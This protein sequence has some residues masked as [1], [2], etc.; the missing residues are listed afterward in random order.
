VEIGRGAERIVAVGRGVAKEAPRAAGLLGWHAGMQLPYAGWSTAVAPGCVVRSSGETLPLHRERLDAGWV[1]GAELARGVSTVT[2]TFAEAPRTVVIVLDDP[3]A[4]GG[5]VGGRQLLLGLDGA[6]RPRDARGRDRPPVLLTME[7]RS[8]L[9]YDVIPQRG[10]PVVVT[11]AS[12]EGWS[13]V[14]VLGSAELTAA[15]AIAL[16]S[17]R[18]LDAAVRPFA[19]G[20]TDPTREAA[21]VSR[22]TWVGPTRTALQRR[23]ARAM[24]AGRPLTPPATDRGTTKPRPKPKPE[25]TPRPKTKPAAKRPTKKTTVKAATKKA[26]TRKAVT[27]KSTA[28]NATAKKATAKKATTKTT[29]KQS[30]RKTATR[31]ATRRP[32][33]S[34]PT[35]GRGRR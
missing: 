13:L 33:K 18:G 8:V 19:A 3:A 5:T 30:T 25:P 9:A 27:K 2:T 28:K 17:S 1:T 15:G 24:A 26:P 32:A 31:S 11:I 22:L 35:R 10:Q 21:E 4:F 20:P 12:E 29:A 16:I 7:N 14:G 23:E 6:V 34:T